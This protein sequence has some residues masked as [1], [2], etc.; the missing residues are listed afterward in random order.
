MAFES[1][2]DFVDSLQRFGLLE[3]EWDEVTRALQLRYQDPRALARELLKRDWLTAYQINQL[4]AGHGQELVVGS[5]R[6]LER[7]G[8]GGMGKVLKAWHR[9][10]DRLVALKVLHR[11]LL[12]RQD[13]VQRFYQEIRVIAQMAHANVV[14]AFDADQINDTYFLAMEYV[15]GIGLGK[16]VEQSGPL[17]ILQAC[18]YIRQAADGL[19]HAHERGLVHRDIKPSNLLVAR[20]PHMLPPVNGGDGETLI[21]TARPAIIKVIDF[22]LARLLPRGHHAEPRRITRIGT[23]MGTPDFIAPEQACDTHTADIRSDLYSLGCTFYF[24]LT[25]RV[26]FPGGEVIDKLRCHESKTPTPVERYRPEVPTGLAAIIRRLMAKK[27]DE[28]HATPQELVDDLQGYLRAGAKLAA[29]QP[30]TP[31]LFNGPDV[32]DLPN[33]TSFNLIG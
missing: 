31:P 1:V 30:C 21:P 13:A 5:Y 3:P 17:S 19:Q 7:L 27:P 4:F 32:D 23:V 28:R 14:F 26:P 33:T 24:L 11:E 16:L 10:L 9:K 12:E 25:G 2:A 22:G 20:R 8:E 6:I 18:D 29:P 15:D